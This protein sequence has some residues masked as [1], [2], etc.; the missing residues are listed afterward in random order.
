M[1]APVL[2]DEVLDLFKDMNLVTFIDGTLGAGGHA[3]AILSAH[4]EIKQ[5]I[6]FDRDPQAMA[7]AKEKLEPFKEKVKIIHAD[8]ADLAEH[9]L[10][11]DGILLDIGVS[12]MQLDLAERGF[13]FSKEGP[14]DMRMN[15]HADLDAQYVVNHYSEKKLGEI[16][17]EYGEERRWKMAAKAICEARKK[18]VISTTTGL[19]KALQPVI[20]FSSG[21][22]HPATRIFQALRIEVNQELKQLEEGIK[23]GLSIL[24]EGGRMAIITFHSLE[25]RIVKHRFKEEKAMKIITKKPITAQSA[26]L[27][28]NRRARSAKLRCIEKCLSED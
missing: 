22:I 3:F 8:Y 2:L 11:A 25:D 10:A 12:S 7:L 24:N 20:G 17:K 19:V 16:F 14:L 1:H 18:Y 15:P 13:S 26:E 21:P 5:Y 9:V 28:L 6:G 4:P 27:R 23:K